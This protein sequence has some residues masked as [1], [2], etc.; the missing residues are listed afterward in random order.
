VHAL[1]IDLLGS[2]RRPIFSAWHPRTSSTVSTSLFSCAL[3]DPGDTPQKNRG[4]RGNSIN[5]SKAESS[6]RVDRERAKIEGKRRSLGDGEADKPS[7]SDIFTMVSGGHIRY[8]TRMTY[9]FS[10]STHESTCT[11]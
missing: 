7:G 11:F 2:P 3:R 1:D 8:S 6:P 5:V 10:D 4:R 9:E